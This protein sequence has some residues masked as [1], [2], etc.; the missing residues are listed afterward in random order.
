MAAASATPE[1][2]DKIRDMFYREKRSKAEI[3]RVLKVSGNTVLKYLPVTSETPYITP[4]DT[5]TGQEF[6]PQA[7][8]VLE[9]PQPIERDVAPYVVTTAGV[10]W[11]VSDAHIPFHDR[12]AL[13][14]GADEASRRGAVGILMNG[15]W[16]DCL[17]L[18]SKFHK[19]PDDHTFKTERKMGQ[20]CLKWIRWK[21]P[22]QRILYKTG[23][24]EERL[25]HYLSQKAPE[26]FDVEELSIASLLGFA[27]HDVELIDDQKLIMLGKLPVLHGHEFQAG[28]TAPVNPARG[29]FLRA[30]HTLM[31]GHH[32]QS[33]EHHERNLMGKQIVTWSTGCNCTL[34]PRYRPYNRWNHGGAFVEVAQDGSFGV[35]NYRIVEGVLR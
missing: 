26:L 17:G 6:V 23:N 31:V 1:L 15:D 12:K 8:P 27:E 9:L 30:T 13:E 21:F 16:L 11:V 35:H 5:P 32:H 25:T 28:L 10:W 19:R 7:T 18:S 20:E 34:T 24:H 4:L 29:V 14:L 33:S 22:T 3:A 2:I